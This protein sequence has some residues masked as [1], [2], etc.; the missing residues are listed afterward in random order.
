MTFSGLDCADWDI[1]ANVLYIHVNTCKLIRKSDC[2]VHINSSFRIR[3]RTGFISIEGNKCMQTYLMSQTKDRNLF[4]NSNIDHQM[5]LRP[6][7]LRNTDHVHCITHFCCCCLM[8]F[9]FFFFFVNFI[10]FL[11][12]QKKRPSLLV[13]FNSLYILVQKSKAG[14]KIAGHHLC[15]NLL[16]CSRR[17]FYVQRVSTSDWKQGAVH[18]G[19]TSAELF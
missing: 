9:L 13:V 8:T 10:L 1:H 3:K 12:F 16:T 19:S 17:L 15:R 14:Q 2:Y 6:N 18:S 11:K 7:Y 5:L 4:M